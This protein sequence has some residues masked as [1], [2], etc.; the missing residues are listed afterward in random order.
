MRV[1]VRLTVLKEHP[2]I[3]HPHFSTTIQSQSEI[4]YA[5]T[6]VGPSMLDAT[7]DAVRGMIATLTVHHGLSDFEGYMLC[8]V[9]GDLKLHEV[10]SV[11]PVSKHGTR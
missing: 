1:T 2:H 4:Y 3:T 5:T 7:K 6:G 8:S 10:A 11:F 9:A